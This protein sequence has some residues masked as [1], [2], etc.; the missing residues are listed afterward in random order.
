MNKKYFFVLFLGAFFLFTACTNKVIVFDESLPDTETATLYWAG[1]ASTVRPVTYNG[2]SVDWGIT[3]WGYTTIKIPAGNATFEVTGRT[4]DRSVNWTWDGFTFTYNFL[5]GNEYT[6]FV[7][8]GR[9][10]I[11]TGK[12]YSEGDIIATFNPGWK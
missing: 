10:S 11:H 8:G 7:A 6:I 9:I 3:G 12:S 5:K 4:G 1:A 2:I